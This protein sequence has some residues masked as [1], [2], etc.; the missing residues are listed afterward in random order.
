VTRAFHDWKRQRR[1][2][3]SGALWLR[4]LSVLV[5]FHVVCV[6]W[7]FFRSESFAKARLVFG[8]LA[9]LTAY[10]PNLSAPVVAVLSLGIA[11]HYVPE[12]WYA[13]ARRVFVAWPAPA[14]GVLLF[15]AC[16]AVRTM[17]SAQAVP[18]VY[19]QF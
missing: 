4:A 6:G 5:T 1:V 13:A 17:A 14:Q 10:H 18:F 19:F 16:L 7:V 12:S 8:R 3:T 9:T 11:S 15:L 2:P